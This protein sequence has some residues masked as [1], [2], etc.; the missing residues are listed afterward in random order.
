[1]IGSLLTKLDNLE[2]SVRTS[3]GRDISS[4]SGRFWAHIHFHLMD[5]AF[6]RVYWNNFHQVCDEVYRANQPSPAHLKSYRD[7][8]IKAVLN[9]RGFAQQSYALFEEDSCKKLG[10][11]LISI[12]LSSSSA[13]QPEKLLEIIDIMEKIPKPFVLH[14]KSGADRAGLVSALYLIVIKKLSVAEAKKQL[15]FKYLHLDFTKTGILD[16]IFDV[17]SE[18][19]KIE[20][21]DFCEWLQKEYNPDILNSSFKSRIEWKRTAKDLMEFSNAKH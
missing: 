17:F 5:H 12:P 2:R 16:Y 15:S 11:E 7:K 9:L 13:P 21:I 18:R 4:I 19:S 3:F 20:D 14:C 10:L 8:G 6:L 1:M